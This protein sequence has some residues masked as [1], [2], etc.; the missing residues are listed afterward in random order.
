MVETI[1]KPVDDTMKCDLVW[2]SLYTS[3]NY[4]CNKRIATLSKILLQYV[5]TAKL[6]LPFSL[7]FNLTN[8][9]DIE[10]TKTK[11]EQYKLENKESIKRNRRKAV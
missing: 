1:S 4:V 7:V 3:Y 10:E 5:T 11:I 2:I 8:G 6:K 9:I